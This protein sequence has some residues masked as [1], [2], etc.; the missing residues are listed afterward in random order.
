M[1]GL[2]QL[3]RVQATGMKQTVRNKLMGPLRVGILQDPKHPPGSTSDKGNNY[4]EVTNIGIFVKL[5]SRDKVSW[6]V[7]LDSFLLCLLHQFSNNG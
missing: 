7:N 3:E 1:W 5:V 4:Y 6:E 2:S